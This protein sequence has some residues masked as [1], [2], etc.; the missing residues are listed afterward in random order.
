MD[1]AGARGGCNCGAVRY[2]ARFA[3]VTGYIC[4]CHLCQK[5]TGAAFSFS[6]VFAAGGVELTEGEPELTE[7]T[8]SRG[9]TSISATCPLC[10]SRLWLEWPAWGSRN[11][12]A[13]TLD[14]TAQV[15]PAAQMWTSSA[16]RWAIA[17]GILSFEGNPPDFA[18]VVE[19][20]R[21]T[22]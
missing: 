5:R 2:Q 21:D 17:P 10:H 4:H 8:N 22:Y 19:A 1:W 20:G 7:K 3:P 11:L 13:G 15:K 16:Q 14:D 12:R 9:E 6:L 18:E